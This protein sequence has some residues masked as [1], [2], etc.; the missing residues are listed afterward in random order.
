MTNTLP[1]AGVGGAVSWPGRHALETADKGY[2][3]LKALWGFLE[4]MKTK[5]FSV[6]L[7]NVALASFSCR[8]THLQMLSC[9]IPLQCCEVLCGV[10]TP[11]PLGKG[12]LKLLLQEALSALPSSMKLVSYLEFSGQ[13][14]VLITSTY[15]ACLVF[16]SLHK[17]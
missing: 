2:L 17:P 10:R 3:L 12:E 15:L 9:P 6:A 16:H 1:G 5:L 11:L 13:A 4:G 14:L 8:P 7:H